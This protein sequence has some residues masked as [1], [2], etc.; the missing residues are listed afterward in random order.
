[1][2][3]CHV[4]GPREAAHL[5]RESVPMTTVIDSFLESEGRLPVSPIVLKIDGKGYE[6]EILRWPRRTTWTAVLIELR[7]NIQTL[8]TLGENRPCLLTFI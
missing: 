6:V 1:M 8:I 7:T 3:E 5:A 2:L 4:A